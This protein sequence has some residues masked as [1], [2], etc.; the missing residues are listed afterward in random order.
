MEQE[1]NLDIP[2][3]GSIEIGGIQILITQ[4]LVST[5]VVGFILILFAVYIRIKLKN[6]KEVPKGIQNVI[7][8]AVDAF[9]NFATGTTGE[10]LSWISGWFFS[11]FVFVF[12]ANIVG[13]FG[14]RTPTADWPLPFALALTTFVLIQVV[15]MKYQ[16]SAYIKGFLAPNFKFNIGSILATLLFLPI[17]LLGELARPVSLSF[18]LFGNVLGGLILLTLLYS[19]APVVIQL[20]LPWALHAYFDLISGALQAFIF[21]VL[22]LSYIAA[23]STLEEPEAT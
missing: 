23:V 4:S 21:T 10:K 2:V 5:W 19:I 16:G 15:G 14:V 11:I 9:S 6:F 18:R 7:E 8:L 22:S 1:V 13:I 20:L 17:N 3:Y 12:F